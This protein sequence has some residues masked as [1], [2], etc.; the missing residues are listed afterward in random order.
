MENAVL[1]PEDRG[2]RVLRV[3]P[4]TRGRSGIFFTAMLH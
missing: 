2:R 1:P 3:E 4:A